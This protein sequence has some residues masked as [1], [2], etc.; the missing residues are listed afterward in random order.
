MRTKVRLWRAVGYLAIC[1]GY[2]ISALGQSPAESTTRPL[3][4]K[5]I[6]SIRQISH[7]QISPNG[8][9]VLFSV[10][11]PQQDGADE[12]KLLEIS[13]GRLEEV[14]INYQDRK[15]GVIWDRKADKLLYPKIIEG[16]LSFCEW[17]LSTKTATELF[18]QDIGKSSLEQFA[19]SAAGERIAYAFVDPLA[20]TAAEDQR[21]KL[22]ATRGVV[23]DDQ[24]PARVAQNVGQ[25]WVWERSNGTKRRVSSG[26]T[27]GEMQ[28][29]PDGS[30]LAFLDSDPGVGDYSLLSWGGGVDLYTVIVDLVDGKT[31]QLRETDLQ[32]TNFLAW[33]P[34]GQSVVVDSGTMTEV[35][36]SP[37]ARLGMHLSAARLQLWQLDQRSHVFR[38]AGSLLEQERSTRGFPY[39]R[40]LR[41]SRNGTV[42]YNEII[43]N[44]TE[45]IALA[46]PGGQGRPL[47]DPNWNLSDVSFSE[48][49]DHAA[50]VRE[51]VNEPQEL[52]VIDLH[53]GAVKTVT[54][55]NAQVAALS[56]ARVEPFRVVN[57][58]GYFTDNWLIKPEGYDPDKKYPL[59]LLLYNFNN[60]FAARPY[61]NNF[62]P[63]EYANLGTIVLLA[64]Y[65]YYDA[66]TG[67]GRQ[68]IPE[69]WR[70]GL[71]VNPLASFEAAIDRLAAQGQ[72]DSSRVAICGFSYGSWLTQYAVTHSSR[73]SLAFLNDGHGA[74]NPDQYYLYGI[75][76][77][78]FIALNDFIFGGSPFG[79][80]ERTMRD[81]LPLYGIGRLA[82]PI[83]FEEHSGDEG[84][85]SRSHIYLTARQ[86]GVPIEL[87]VYKGEHVLKDRQQQLSS[88]SRS[89][90]WLRYWLLNAQNPNPL[91]KDEYA[92][93]AVLRKR[94]EVLK[95]Q[96]A[97]N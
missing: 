89:S 53:T 3:E 81:F 34:D 84:I 78:G 47:S 28:W 49:A 15:H 45:V 43:A 55:L 54:S 73:F 32:E 82:I 62:A 87:V 66:A 85:D 95:R 74:W 21:K 17:S 22:L 60:A 83:L 40:W 80:G 9:Q 46:K 7:V 59:V 1:L 30:K 94:L 27:F 63:F 61:M 56:H 20:A 14:S 65:P 36:A 24:E 91:D 86:E 50:A 77:P 19:V 41:W 13:T 18:S 23:F 52:A 72:I 69:K 16:K 88:I 38:P 67:E 12:L 26:G 29:S 79:R 6:W 39:G 33:S 93:W 51:S 44:R 75:R 76:T 58:F 92:R 71:A 68:T 2:L 10:T 35:G 57:R 37:A 8:K 25:V 11:S 4:L 5:D 31:Q 42:F 96:S 48:D 64:N 97:H 70:F 90:D